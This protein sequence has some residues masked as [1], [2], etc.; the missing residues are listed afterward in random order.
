M[1]AKLARKWVVGMVLLLGLI[2]V[3]GGWAAKRHRT[4][5]NWRKAPDLTPSLS[6][7]ASSPASGVI[8]FQ[9]AGTVTHPFRNPVLGWRVVVT[10]IG[11]VGE[12]GVAFREEYWDQRHTTRARKGVEAR[13]ALDERV[14]FRV[15]AGT[16]HV[17]VSLREDAGEVSAFGDA[18]DT[19][20]NVAGLST[21][22]DV[23]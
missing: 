1:R 15:P 14:P 22:V 11:D 16:Y 7:K 5:P 4:T 2:T 18:L 17:F 8:A 21:Y 9:A 19:S 6:V 20:H 13:P 12:A 10:R 3:A 23:K